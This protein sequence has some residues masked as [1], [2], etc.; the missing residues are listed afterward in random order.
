M[1]TAIE[2]NGMPDLA[3]ECKKWEKQ[4]AELVE[5]RDNLRAE[6]GKV[7]SERDQYLKSLYFYIR[8]EAP[9]LTFTKEEVFAH[10]DD[11]PTFQ[12]LIDELCGT[13]TQEK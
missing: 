13:D 6:L 2:T 11:K 5:E 9:P 3:A 8:K 7:R 12:E 1:S 4:C 10:L